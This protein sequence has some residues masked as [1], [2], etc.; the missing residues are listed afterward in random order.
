MHELGQ[1][2][3]VNNDE[4][5]W[6]SPSVRSCKQTPKL[7]EELVLIS[8]DFT[9]YMLFMRH[10]KFK[11]A[12]KHFNLYNNNN[13]YTLKLCLFGFFLV[14]VSQKLHFISFTSV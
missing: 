7:T 12:K 2:K 11:K 14:V 10:L 6:S 3:T 1:M 4:R 13:Y 9:C 5:S 8:F